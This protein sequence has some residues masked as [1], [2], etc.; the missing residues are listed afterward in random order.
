MP[1]ERRVNMPTGIA[2]PVELG[3]SAD[4]AG[5]V[6]SDLE[7][8][9][10]EAAMDGR[11]ATLAELG[12]IEVLR[13]EAPYLVRS[14]MLP[15]LAR[16][17]VQAVTEGNASDSDDCSGNAAPDVGAVI[18]LLLEGLRDTTS[19]LAFDETLEV[20]LASGEVLGR[21]AEALNRVCLVRTD[22]RREQ[23]ALAGTAL[24]GAL[25]MALGGWVPEYD[26]LGVLV[27]IDG[28]QSHLFARRALR[29]LGVAYEQWRDRRLAQA[30]MYVAGLDS[31]VPEEFTDDVA[32]AEADAAF[33]LGQVSLL[34]A[35]SSPNFTHA[36]EHLETAHR[37][38]TVA[39]ADEDRVDA[40]IMASAVE[41]L[42]TQLLAARDGDAL[43]GI[44]V[45]ER[46]TQLA[47]ELAVAVREH[48][49]GYA[50]LGHWHGARLDAE[51]AWASLARDVAATAD[52]LT[53]TSWYAA[54]RTLERVLAAYQATRC[55]QVLVKDEDVAGLRALLAP[56]ITAGIAA[57]AALL[58][59][60]DDHVRA[61]EACRTVERETG[62]LSES[63]AAEIDAARK[64]LDS[65]SAQFGQTGGGPPKRPG[66][67]RAARHDYLPR[68]NALL[69]DGDILVRLVADAPDAV[70]AIEEA[71]TDA[72]DIASTADSLV[73]SEV[74]AECRRQLGDCPD[75][76]DDVREAVDE[77]L[78]HLLR[79]AHSR[80]QRS[81]SR[82][83]AGYLFRPDALEK[84]L[85]DDLDEFLAASD[86]G[87]R[88]HT[89]VRDI[90][91]GRVD[92]AAF[93]ERFTL[94]CELKRE[95]ADVSVDGQRR[96]LL[97]AAAYQDSD[98]AVGFLLVLDQR[99]RTGPAPHLR[100]NVRVVVLDEGALGGAR[101]VVL[102]VVPGNRISP[103][104]AT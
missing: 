2:Q 14:P 84:D 57:N 74:F 28:P 93:Y 21:H 80:A 104:S 45:A 91:G 51:V 31:T 32:L 26:V 68:L 86:L 39:R 16:S 24:E 67:V 37:R 78:L 98:V 53:Q 83:G 19:L 90:G 95:N 1:D 71:L 102:L 96:H 27:R 55:A 89:E 64:L 42:T 69:P 85:A 40:R 25:R 48:T 103:S 18:D 54:A 76:R 46:L 29:C 77:L 23:P 70:R 49:L 101:H 97:Q 33:E 36:S 44:Q 82:R 4:L 94:V 99:A 8:V 43:G 87:Y 56:R 22:D 72:E 7:R 9:L 10:S 59:H 41:M 47:G 66:A 20:L 100:L 15:E 35:L 17:L 81:R 6:F 73:V 52:A 13:R 50:G 30:M 34:D 61:L 75:Y 88:V 38:F 62:D 79:F 65:A 92:V 12:G 63:L 5:G 3:A 60:L 58:T 11:Y